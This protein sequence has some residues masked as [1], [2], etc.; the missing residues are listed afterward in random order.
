M[1]I[2]TPAVNRAE[3]EARALQKSTH[4]LFII[5]LPARQKRTNNADDFHEH[6]CKLA[7]DMACHSACRLASETEY[8]RTVDSFAVVLTSPCHTQYAET[9]R[10]V[11]QQLHASENT[12]EHYQLIL[13]FLNGNKEMDRIDEDFN[14]PDAL[15][16]KENP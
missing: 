3:R 6:L 14:T 1:S 13:A 16:N 15:K 11:R 8:L 2:H 7:T 4:V 12:P 10:T 5:R 9:L